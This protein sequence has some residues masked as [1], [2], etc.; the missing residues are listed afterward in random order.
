MN[1][2]NNLCGSHSKFSFNHP[3]SRGEISLELYLDSLSHAV[4]KEFIPGSIQDCSAVFDFCCAA[5]CSHVLVKLVENLSSPGL[6]LQALHQVLKSVQEYSTREDSNDSACSLRTCENSCTQ[7]IPDISESTE[8]PLLGSSP[9]MQGKEEVGN[10]DN[11]EHPF[12]SSGKSASPVLAGSSFSCN[13]LTSSA[14]QISKSSSWVQSCLSNS[15]ST[16]TVPLLPSQFVRS[17]EDEDEEKKRMCK[18]SSLTLIGTTGNIIGSLDSEPTSAFLVD[19][20]VS[21][22]YEV[23]VS[24]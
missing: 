1:F 23:I 10:T 19:S 11:S 9:R 20:E 4:M 6:V 14:H 7:E 15:L 17:S 2:C 18:P 21:P 13:S 22:V 12:S 3:V 8:D 5:F 24:F 16:V